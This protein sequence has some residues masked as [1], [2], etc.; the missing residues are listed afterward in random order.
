M[1][2]LYDIQKQP[3]EGQVVDMDKIRAELKNRANQIDDKIKQIEEAQFVSQE[4]FR[5][6]F[7][8]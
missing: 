3:I 4:T 5:M 7:T 1:T 6:E 2:D 8:V